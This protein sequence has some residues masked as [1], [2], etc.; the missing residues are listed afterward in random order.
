MIFFM[1]RNFEFVLS[2]EDDFFPGWCRQVVDIHDVQD[3]FMFAYGKY[4]KIHVI[5]NKVETQYRLVVFERPGSGYGIQKRHVRLALDDIFERFETAVRVKYP[6]VVSLATI[7]I[8]SKNTVAVFIL[9]GFHFGPGALGEQVGRVVGHDESD[10]HDAA[11]S[12][13]KCRQRGQ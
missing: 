6:V 3:Q 7:G 10:Q 8:E 5:F 11:G 2:A 13:Q 9:P 4:L 1:L 12:R